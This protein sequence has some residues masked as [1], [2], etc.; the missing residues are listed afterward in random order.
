MSFRAHI[1][2]LTA[3]FGLAAAIPSNA[4]AAGATSWNAVT[5]FSTSSNPNGVWSYGYGTPG[6]SFTSFTYSGSNFNGPDTS[7]AYWAGGISGIP[8]VG[9]GGASFSTVDVPSNELW[10]HPGNDPTLASI[11]EFT[12][13]TTA[14]YEIIGAFVRRDTSDGTG[15]GPIVSIYAGSNDLL[16]E[17][18]SSSAYGNAITFDD[19]ISLTAGEQLT[20]DVAVNTEYYNDSTGLTLGITDVPEPASLIL[21][22]TGLLGLGMLRRRART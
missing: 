17:S 11:V 15:Y 12:A 7:G 20:F 14:N 10:M 2:T 3:L 9:G 22:G 6:S 16:S 19:V 4:K 8:V 21:L 5:D 1:L 13:P 18:L